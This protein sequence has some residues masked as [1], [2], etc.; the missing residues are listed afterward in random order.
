MLVGTGGGFHRGRERAERITSERLA[1]LARASPVPRDRRLLQDQ[2]PI[3]TAAC[4]AGGRGLPNCG[5]L[6]VTQPAGS[7]IRRGGNVNRCCGR[8]Y[9]GK[10][11]G[12]VGAE[13]PWS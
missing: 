1:R 12:R 8:P 11:A 2:G 13:L 6:G 3:T 4:A 10:L 9:E 5:R 7:D